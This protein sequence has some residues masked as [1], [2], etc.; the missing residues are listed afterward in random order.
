MSCLTARVIL[1]QALSIATFVSQ[2]QVFQ[3][4]LNNLFMSL[5]KTFSIETLHIFV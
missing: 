1:G 5:Q 4:K 2:T 3:V